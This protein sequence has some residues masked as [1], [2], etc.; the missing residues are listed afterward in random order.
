MKISVIA[1]ALSLGIAAAG[2]VH[3]AT[4]GSAAAK[5]AECSKEGRAKGLHGKP[6][7]RFLSE[8]RKNMM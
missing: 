3:A 5:S 7:K 4:S 2:P 6:L 1:I 8:C